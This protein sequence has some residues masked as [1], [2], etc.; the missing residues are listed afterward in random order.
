MRWHWEPGHFKKELGDLVLDRILDVPAPADTPVEDFGIKLTPANIESHLAGVR[1][2]R[3]RY[4]PVLRPFIDL[5][6]ER[7]PTPDPSQYQIPARAD[8]TP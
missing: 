3:D 4:L 1:S 7:A 6:N 2:H 8:Q 5:L